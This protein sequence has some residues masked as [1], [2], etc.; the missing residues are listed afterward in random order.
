MSAPVGDLTT[1]SGVGVP[2]TRSSW[3]CRRSAAS[4]LNWRC[5]RSGG[6]SGTCFSDSSTF[7]R[8]V[9]GPPRAIASGRTRISPG[10]GYGYH[11]EGSVTLHR[12]FDLGPWGA[13][14]AGQAASSWIPT[15][16]VTPLPPDLTA[17]WLP[18]SHRL[19]TALGATGRALVSL[20]A[21][22]LGCD[23]LMAAAR[24]QPDH[25]TMRILEYPELGHPESISFARANTRTREP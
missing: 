4:P 20:I 18:A 17:E 22:G 10:L 12:T 21:S 15:A 19:R 3:P 6:S 11:R 7:P 25:S 2:G 5:L 14:S 13:A 8:K 1:W 23:P 9:C 24:F 16:E